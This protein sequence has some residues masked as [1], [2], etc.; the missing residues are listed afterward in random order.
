MKTSDINK[1]PIEAKKNLLK[2]FAAGKLKKSDLKSDEINEILLN[3]GGDGWSLIHLNCW[4]AN[5]YKHNN[6]V[7]TQI[8]FDRLEILYNAIY[9][10]RVN[11]VRIEENRN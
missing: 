5:E 7:I 3:S 9:P 1:L 2:A 4:G 6:K 10:D 8:D 11:S